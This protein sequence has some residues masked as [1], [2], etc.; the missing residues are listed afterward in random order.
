MDVQRIACYGHVLN[1]LKMANMHSGIYVDQG[2]IDLEL[3]SDMLL[4]LESFGLMSNSVVVA[5]EDN[6]NKS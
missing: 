2:H 5:D 6:L 1:G 3:T 4:A